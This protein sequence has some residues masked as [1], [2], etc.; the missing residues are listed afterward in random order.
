MNDYGG[1][2][3]MEL[4]MAIPDGKLITLNFKYSFKN[5]LLKTDSSTIISSF[6]SF[7]NS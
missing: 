5:G 6:S 7:F 2:V 1:D 4:T 3:M